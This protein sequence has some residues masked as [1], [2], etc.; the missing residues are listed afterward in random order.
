MT[1]KQQ[2]AFSAV[3]LI[4]EELWKKYDKK[5]RN[6]AFVDWHSRCPTFICLLGQEHVAINVSIPDFIEIQLYSSW[7]EEKRIY[8]E[9]SDK[10]ETFYKFI[11]R[12]FR[13]IK[14]ELNAIKI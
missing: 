7:T 1:D 8:Y 13:E 11:K 3:Q 6:D 9:K 2:E 10:Y 12:R 4:N 5:H 14:E